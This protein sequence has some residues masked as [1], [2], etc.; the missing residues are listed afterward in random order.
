MKA[1]DKVRET[2]RHIISL[3]EAVRSGE[4]YKAIEAGLTDEEIKEK[5]DISDRGVAALR[6]RYKS[7]R[8]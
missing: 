4:G 7:E 2:R 5:L 1:I 6:R 8:S 3:G